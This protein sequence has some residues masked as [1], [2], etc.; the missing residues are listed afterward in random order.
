MSVLEKINMIV[1]QK[2]NKINT[3]FPAKVIDV[4]TNTCIIKPKFYYEF[5]YRNQKYTR[6][7]PVIRDVPVMW[8]RGGK[9][10]VMFPISAG[11]IVFVACSQYSLKKLL[12]NLENVKVEQA[13]EFNL[14]GAVILGGFTLKNEWGTTIYG[15]ST[16]D[17][18][19]KLTI[20]SD[21]EIIIE[22]N[23]VR[24]GG[25]TNNISIANDGTMTMN[26]TARKKTTIQRGMEE[27]HTPAAGGAIDT[28]IGSGPYRDA[29]KFI[30]NNSRYVW[31]ILQIPEDMDISEDSE[32]I[33]Y[34]AT[35]A[36]SGDCQWWVRHVPFALNED[37]TQNYI[38]IINGITTT[39]NQNMGLDIT[40]ATVAA[41]K[42]QSG[43][44]LFSVSINREGNS[45]NDTLSADVFLLAAAWRYTRNKQGS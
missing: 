41:A 44:K 17:I 30:D 45:G 26:G 37:V 27:M 11:D 43:D 18:P 13:K 33:L 14:D 32:I 7:P 12:I 39:G 25:S 9:S 10:I 8:M 19:S 6:E 28:E 31:L 24:I 22:S 1:D 3:L 42:I 38:D 36:T 29:W 20:A 35:T 5:E 16:F 4:G 23:G 2:V 40:T 34:W 15:G 21:D